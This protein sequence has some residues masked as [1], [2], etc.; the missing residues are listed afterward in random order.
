MWIL[1]YNMY[2][3]VYQQIHTEKM[4][5][6]KWNYELS[7][8]YTVHLFWLAQMLIYGINSVRNFQ[9]SVGRKYPYKVLRCLKS[10]WHV[11]KSAEHFGL[12]AQLCRSWSCP[13]LL[14]LPFS[15]A[16]GRA[17]TDSVFSLATLQP[18]PQVWVFNCKCHMGNAEMFNEGLMFF[19]L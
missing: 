13:L 8:T 18:W 3:L 4:L 6:K 7:W 16:F 10:C 2:I 5:E 19:T 9:W 14:V 1:I 15:Q 17:F 11:Q 12:V